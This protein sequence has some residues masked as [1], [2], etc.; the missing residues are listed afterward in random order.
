VLLEE[1]KVVAQGQAAALLTR[2]D[3]SP[4][5]EDEA[6]SLLEG[7]VDAH[8]SR[9]HLTWIALES[10]RVAVARVDL[11]VGQRTRVQIRARD[12]SLSLTAHVDTS[13]LNIL[14]ATVLDTH[15]LNPSQVLVRLELADGQTLL[16]RI[17][18]RSASMLN[19]RPGQRLY[20]QV[21]SVALLSSAF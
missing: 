16:A 17:T 9:F 7:E 13:I 1:G 6:A 18:R 14:P 4:A 10:D 21:K 19:I 11:P 15:D 5:S 2:L 3:L 20:A 8:D 12:V